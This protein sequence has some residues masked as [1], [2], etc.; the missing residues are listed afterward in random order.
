MS[1]VIKLSV[2][3]FWLLYHKPVG[4]VCRLG[5][6]YLLWAVSAWP[7]FHGVVGRDGG[8]LA[9]AERGALDGLVFVDGGIFVRTRSRY[10][11]LV[12]IWTSAGGHGETWG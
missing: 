9:H 5:K 4:W 11:H 8:T 3:Y 1:V 7:G 12:F 2:D 6:T 10:F